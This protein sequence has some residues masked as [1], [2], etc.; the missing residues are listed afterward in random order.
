MLA[1][2]LF[3]GTVVVTTAA[4]IGLAMH[5]QAATVLQCMFVTACAGNQ[6]RKGFVH[7]DRARIG[8][9]CR[10]NALCPKKQP[11]QHTSSASSSSACD[12]GASRLPRP[13]PPPTCRLFCTGCS[14]AA[15]SLGA[16]S[17]SLKSRLVARLALSSR[18]TLAARGWDQ[19]RRV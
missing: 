11:Q 2:L 6:L 16:A 9:A 10:T 8:T 5:A 17:C 1:R 15:C 18:S 3:P 13:L 12:E 4:A 14:G 19:G 7:S